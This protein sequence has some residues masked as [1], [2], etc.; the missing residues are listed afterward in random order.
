MAAEFDQTT[1]KE[2]E[3]FDVLTKTG[4]KTGYSKPRWTTPLKKQENFIWVMKN[5]D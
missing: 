1:V 3:Y 5:F 4:E 2:E